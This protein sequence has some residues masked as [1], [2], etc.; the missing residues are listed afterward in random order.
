[1][2]HIITTIRLGLVA[3]LAGLSLGVA[4]AQAQSPAGTMVA[5]IDSSKQAV[6]K[7]AGIGGS[8]AGAGG[9][10]RVISRVIN[11]LSTIVGV[12]AVIMVIISGFKYITSGGDPQK[13][14]GAKMT[15]IYAIIGL[16]IVALA[17]ILVRFV[18]G[19]AS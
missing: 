13:A 7:G 4:T 6:C 1:M 5:S 17:Q 2:K 16:V 9:L 11:I 10:N 8:C 12:V 3:T 18:I 15:L 19:Q 14:S